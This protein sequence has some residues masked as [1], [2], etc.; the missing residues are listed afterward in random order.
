M[1]AQEVVNRVVSTGEDSGRL[2]ATTYYY[3][4]PTQDYLDGAARIMQP[5]LQ[6]GS[7][8]SHVP[9]PAVGAATGTVIR[10]KRYRNIVSTAACFRWC[11]NG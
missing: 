10:R 2:A 11:A 4:L 1:Y 9:L 5:S 7:T 3:A 6:Y 8:M